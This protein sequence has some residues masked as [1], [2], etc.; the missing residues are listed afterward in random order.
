MLKDPDSDIKRS[1]K[2]IR[3]PGSRCPT[4]GRRKFVV[5]EGAEASQLWI[6]SGGGY[7]V[8]SQ[9]LTPTAV[10]HST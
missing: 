5:S 7:Q 9:S 10:R 6:R 2:V 4:R 8:L 1:K 3:G